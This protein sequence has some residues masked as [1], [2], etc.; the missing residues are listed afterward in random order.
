MIPTVREI[1]YS[2]YGA[3]RL[4]R[5]DRGGL[6]YFDASVAGFWKSF[7]AAALVAPGYLVLVLLD[8]AAGES[9]A[10]FLRIAVIH[11]LTYS[12]SWTVYPVLVHPICQAMGR[13]PA[14]IGFIVAFNWIK[15]IQMAAYIPVVAIVAGE[16]LP[17]GPS[18]LLNTAVYVL[19]LAYQWFV[20]R[21]ALDVRP[22]AAAGLVV[23][24]FVIG[25]IISV[26]ALG[27]LR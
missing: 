20:T 19:L 7:F 23:L 11:I 17:K 15:V 16:I 25:V 24:D 3:W 8:P 27:M 2:L 18:D 12:L 1:V 6:T 21:A 9:A 4:A 22:L 5:V 14:Y 26:L 13:E 10:G